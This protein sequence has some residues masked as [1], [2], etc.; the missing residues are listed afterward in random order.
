MQKKYYSPEL[1]REAIRQV[2]EFRLP[3]KAVAERL[4]VGKDA[5]GVWVR[6]YRE[7]RCLAPAIDDFAARIPHGAS[8]NDLLKMIALHLLK[9]AE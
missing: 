6:R 8:G 7:R 2:V 9:D 4:H 5:V 1:R 3:A